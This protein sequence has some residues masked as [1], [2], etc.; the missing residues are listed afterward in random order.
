MPTYEYLCESCRQTIERQQAMKDQPETICPSC[1]G[2]LRRL[3]SG[4]TG[5]ILKQASPATPCVSGR[6][7]SLERT[8]QAC[9]GRSQ[10]CGEPPC[11][12]MS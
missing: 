10:R 9:C 11:E 7:C 2:T 8:G 4:G 6:G 1:G 3:I 5:F 12:E